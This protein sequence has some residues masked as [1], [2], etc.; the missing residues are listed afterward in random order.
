[1]IRA[2]QTCFCR[3]FRSATIRSSRSRSAALTSMLIPSRMPQ[4]ATL[5]S[6]RESYDCV[7]PLGGGV[8]EMLDIRRLVAE[9]RMEVGGVVELTP[10]LPQTSGDRDPISTGRL[11]SRLISYRSDHG[12]AASSRHA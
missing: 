12:T 5:P 3:L 10:S 1:M 6:T 9:R 11:E 2:R 8:A 4:H 7:I